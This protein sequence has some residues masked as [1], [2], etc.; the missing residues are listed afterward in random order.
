MDGQSPNESASA[1]SRLLVMMASALRLGLKVHITACSST[2][3]ARYGQP[4]RQSS[5]VSSVPSVA[6]CAPCTS[7][8][9][10][11]GYV[12]NCSVCSVSSR[13]RNTLSGVS[14]P[15]ID[16]LRPRKGPWL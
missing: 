12:S 8:S 6:T 14:P 13:L 5:H 2:Q 7:H 16:I 3:N 4:E 11:Q 1:T 9:V 15:L 10:A